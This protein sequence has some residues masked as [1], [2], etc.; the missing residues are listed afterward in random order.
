MVNCKFC[1]GM[2]DLKDIDDIV[3]HIAAQHLIVPDDEVVTRDNTKR[4]VREV[5]KC[6]QQH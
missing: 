3:R 1:T 4:L 2:T 5:A 6:W